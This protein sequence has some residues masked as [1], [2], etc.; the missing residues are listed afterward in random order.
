M[1]QWSSDQIRDSGASLEADFNGFTLRGI[2]KLTFK[3]NLERDEQ[4]ANSSVSI[5]IPAGTY[6]AEGTLETISAEADGLRQSLGTNF[7][8]IPGSI[9][10]SLYEPNGA[11]LITYNLTRVYL[12]GGGEVTIESG[13]QKSVTETLSFK[14]LDPI[15]WNGVQALT[16][17]AASIISLPDFGDLDL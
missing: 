17:T 14:I 16:D 7:T 3:D 12:Q 15:D 2:A 6:K 8:Q 5:G 1:G 4:F 13:G 9:G 11:G 10:V